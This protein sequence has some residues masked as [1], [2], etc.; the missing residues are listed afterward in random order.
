MKKVLV[1]IVVI[2][3]VGLGT[4]A[5][6]SVG[7]Y[8]GMTKEQQLAFHAQLAQDK[9]QKLK[10]F[11]DLDKKGV[12]TQD[13]KIISEAQKAGEDFKRTAV[14]EATVQGEVDAVDYDAE[15]KKLIDAA[16]MEIP[17]NRD[18][19][20]DRYKVIYDEHMRKVKEVCAK[21]SQ[22]KD[23]KKLS[24]KEAFQQLQSELDHLMSDLQQK[25]QNLEQKN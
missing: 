1:P 7:K 19:F 14:E 21:Y 11:E 3:L 8:F 12:E 20:T 6:S 17:G 4:V 22:L 15:M 9:S 16:T 13:P 23:E 18:S 25:Q 24:S 2:V 10:E 5:V